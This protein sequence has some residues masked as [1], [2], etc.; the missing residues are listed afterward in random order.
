METQQP[1]EQQRESVLPSKPQ[2]LQQNVLEEER[3]HRPHLC[4]DHLEDIV[5][6]STLLVYAAYLTHTKG[7]MLK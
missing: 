1:M 5:Q 7:C 6:V 4:N 3:V 2:L